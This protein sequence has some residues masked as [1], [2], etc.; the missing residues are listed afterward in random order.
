R[1]DHGR[2]WPSGALRTVL[3]SRLPGKNNPVAPRPHLFIRLER[4]T[5]NFPLSWFVPCKFDYLLPRTVAQD[6]DHVRQERARLRQLLGS[7]GVD[8]LSS[9]DWS[10][11]I[12]QDFVLQ[13]FC[14]TKRHHHDSKSNRGCRHRRARLATAKT[15]S[16]LAVRLDRAGLDDFLRPLARSSSSISCLAGPFCSLSFPD[17][18]RISRR[19]QLGLSFRPLH[20][21]VRR[22]P[23]VFC[24]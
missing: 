23:L 17:V 5:S 22:F 20:D 19:R 21:H 7:L 9:D 13:S 8:L 12:Q 10:E 1:L 18:L 4:A 6:A 11:R 2:S 14:L 15:A 16:A 3:S 24:A